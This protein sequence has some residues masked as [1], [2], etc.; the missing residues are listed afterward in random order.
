M[1]RYSPFEMW[2]GIMTAFLE[3][4]EPIMFQ[5]NKS[6]D[7]IVEQVSLTA[8]FPADL[9]ESSAT[10]ASVDELVETRGIGHPNDIFVHAGDL[11][12]LTG[13]SLETGR[14][15]L[16]KFH[17]KDLLQLH[18]DIGVMHD[19]EMRSVKLYLPVHND[20]KRVMRTLYEL[21][22]GTYPETLG[23]LISVTPSQFIHLDGSKYQYRDDSTVTVDVKK[24]EGRNINLQDYVNEQLHTHGLTPSSPKNFVYELRK[25]AS[26]I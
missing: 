10:E 11:A 3:E 6:T 14:N 23:D 8:G 26:L 9:I 19:D 25:Q 4:N 18:G 24:P 2:T 7:S 17:E 16:Q 5:E 21:E 12:A 22:K 1:P 13:C 20:S 15:W